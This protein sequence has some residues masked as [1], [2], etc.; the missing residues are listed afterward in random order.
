MVKKF[1]KVLAFDLDETIGYFQQLSIFISELELIRKKKIS[2]L[3]FNIICDLFPEFFRYKIFE[4]FSFIKENNSYYDK[5]IIYTNNTGYK[6]WV[7]RIK[8]YI[9]HKLNFKL[10]NKVI[11]AYMI[12]GKLIEKCR[13]SY[14]KKY[15]DLINCLKLSNN[16][17]VIFFDDQMH[18]DLYR[19]NNVVYHHNTIYKYNLTA[20]IMINR[21]KSSNIKYNR[22]DNLKLYTKL[23]QYIEFKNNV[24]VANISKDYREIMIMYKKISLFL[25]N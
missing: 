10:F 4:L 23:K 5:V 21:L 25:F 8:K 20:E 15:S 11:Y 6:L 9:E 24:I 17:K 13:T 14:E 22:N 2:Q 19:N 16:T 18:I 7:N 1:K 3:E 12:D